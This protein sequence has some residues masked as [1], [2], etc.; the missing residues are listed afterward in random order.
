M[1]IFY[2]F[3]SLV[4]ICAFVAFNFASNFKGA[5]KAVQS[6][7]MVAGVIGFLSFLA[8]II[9]LF[10]KVTWWHPLIILVVVF[11]GGGFIAGLFRGFVTAVLS[12]IGIVL[13]TILSW[14]SMFNA[15]LF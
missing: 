7:F 6:I 15:F 5:S 9:T 12:V 13:F 1:E 11:L 8:L 2:Y 10:I 14:T 3:V 4:G